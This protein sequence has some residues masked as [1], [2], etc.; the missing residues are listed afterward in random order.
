MNNKNNSKWNDEFS[1]ESIDRQ[2]KYNE[3]LI[4]MMC[5]TFS[6]KQ[7][8]QLVEIYIKTNSLT[9]NIIKLKKDLEHKKEDRKN[10]EDKLYKLKED[11]KITKEM[12]DEI[13]IK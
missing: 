3:A 9:D 6:K 13:K 2:E 8:K 12:F 5:L 7:M 1:F 4:E 10:M 11:F